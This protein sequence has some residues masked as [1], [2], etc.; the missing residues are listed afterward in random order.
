MEVTAKDALAVLDCVQTLHEARS[1]AELFALVP[2]ALA[3][4]VPCDT[5]SVTAAATTTEPTRLCD[6]PAGAL[7]GR[8]QPHIDGLEVHPAVAYFLRTGH[9]DVCAI[10]DLMPR[11]QWRGTRLYRTLFRPYEVEDQI[12]VAIDVQGSG[13]LGVGVNRSRPG[14]TDRERAR[15]SLVSR[16]LAQAYITM[17]R[18][19]TVASADSSTT[20]LLTPRERDVLELVGRGLTDAQI[21]RWLGVSTRTVSK[22]LEHSYDKLG[23]R[24]RTAAWRVAYGA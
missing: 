24:T 2:A 20:E 13:A 22:H 14:F 4:L 1:S 10:N 17:R 15:L 8:H 16:H 5:A 18:L 9:R 19:D 23:V 7:T 12:S 21:A 6:H 3:Q 11:R